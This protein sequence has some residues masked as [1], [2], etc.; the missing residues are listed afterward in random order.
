MGLKEAFQKSVHEKNLK[1]YLLEVER[2]KD[3][4]QTYIDYDEK[5][6]YGRLITINEANNLDS[7]LMVLSFDEL[8]SDI[9][10]IGGGCPFILFV[11]KDGCLSECVSQEVIRSFED[12]PDVNVLYFDEDL[13]NRDTMKRHDPWFKSDFAR[14]SLLES[15]YLGN[16]VAIRRSA[17]NDEEYAGYNDGLKNIYNI[18]LQLTENEP[19]MHIDQVMYHIFDDENV[20][21]ILGAGTLYEDIRSLAYKRLGAKVTFDTDDYG[22]SHSVVAGSG[23]KVSIVIPSKD[24][25]DILERCVSSVRNLSIYTNYEIIVVDNG[26]GVEKAAYEALA[27]K[28]DFKYIYEQMDFNFSKMCNIGAGASNGEYLLFLN[29][30][31]E[32]VTKDWLEKLLGT[33]T[34]KHVG[35]VGAKL[36]YPDTDLIQHIGITNMTEGPAHKLQGHSDAVSYYHGVNRVNRDVIGVTAA[37]LMISKDKF[38]NAEGFFEGLEVAY[39]DVDLC[40]KL[41]AD[42]LNNVIRNDVI[43][44]HHESLSRGDDNLDENKMNRLFMERARL[45]SRFPFFYGKDIYYSAHLT[46]AGEEYTVVLPYENRNIRPIGRPDEYKC[47]KG[48]INETLIIKVDRAGLEPVSIGGHLCV[49]IDLHAHVRGLDSSDYTYTMYIKNGSEGMKLPSVRR[50]RPDV[51]ETYSDQV[52]VE[53]S[54]F[55]VRIPLTLLKPGTYEIWMEAKSIF[56]RQVLLNKAET[57]FEITEEMFKSMQTIK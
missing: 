37:C 44:F 46:G 3:A 7:D 33:A 30:D 21:D 54:G 17:I 34:L 42:E 55:A 45:F 40:F 29:D 35:A 16:I 18:V 2:Q 38:N 11:N 28:Y 48:E 43:L 23:E 12:Y 27:S 15:F 24:H 26:S 13:V 4:Y 56:S 51:V 36:L 49:L 57:T 19:A 25:A 14:D 6:G 22:L 20:D 31:M 50:I 1:K 5:Q 8:L 52:H 47:P 32:V 39:N 9:D 41:I 53:L 10:V